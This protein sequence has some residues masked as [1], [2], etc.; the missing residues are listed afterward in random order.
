MEKR[1]EGVE[2]HISEFV[3]NV[4]FRSNATACMN[5]TYSIGKSVRCLECPAGHKCPTTNVSFHRL[6]NEFSVLEQH[7]TG[8]HSVTS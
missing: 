7:Y 8:I 1:E 2:R 6:N 3:S 5:G 4:Y